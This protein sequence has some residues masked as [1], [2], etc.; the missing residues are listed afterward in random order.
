MRGGDEAEPG[1]AQ[2]TTVAPRGARAR[3]AGR[4]PGWALLSALLVLAIAASSGLVF[5]NQIELLKLAV[6]L[7]LWA[8]IV[9]AFASV[10]YRRQSDTD[11][12]RARDLKLVYDLQLDREISARRE[13][14]LSVE[15]RLRRELAA[16]LRDQAADEVAAL[17]AE[18]SALR[19]NLEIWFDTELA[20]RP[21]LE[22]ERTTVRAYSD[23]ARD[24]E[25]GPGARRAH[26]RIVVLGDDITQTA[27][28]PIIDVS[29]VRVPAESGPPPAARQPAAEPAETHRGSHR[30]RASEDAAWSPR[31]AH[32]W[33]SPEPA[34]PAR[35]TRTEP[36][37]QAEQWWPSE[38]A[39][40]TNW[41]PAPAEGEWLPPGTPGSNWVAEPVANSHD[42]TAD[43]ENA[44]EQPARRSRHSRQDGPAEAAAVPEPRRHREGR[45]RAEARHS[46]DSPAPV[47]ASAGAVSRHAEVAEPPA[48]HSD[49]ES[50]THSTG[51]E[52]VA[53]L[54]ARLE[55]ESGGRRG[56]RRRAD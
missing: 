30:G 18:L 53:E 34:Q 29:E 36:P 12:A 33:S 17:R 16:E 48:R 1:A 20:N 54:L 6:I 24:G 46:V 47:M 38:A 27:E 13:Y 23:W 55:T 45:R 2:L 3:R 51:A 15:S 42:A 25:D 7:A 35:E 11:A 5:S 14:E 39:A 4:R 21:A 41:Q 26:E 44:A 37:R 19:A 40:T 32:R 10:I 50:G 9:A 49:A 22:T 31:N 56:R 43:T 28:N 8:A 52:S